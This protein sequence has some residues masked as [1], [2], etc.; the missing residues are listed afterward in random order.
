MCSNRTLGINDRRFSSC[1]K[2]HT[3]VVADEVIK[4]FGQ[5]S[6]GTRVF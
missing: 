4:R 2:Y 1:M 6:H 5:I 3:I